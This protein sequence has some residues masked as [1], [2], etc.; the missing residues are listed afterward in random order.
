MAVWLGD[1]TS[2]C[3]ICIRTV[4]FNAHQKQFESDGAKMN[5]WT[6]IAF[7]LQNTISDRCLNRMTV[8]VFAMYF[9]NSETSSIR[10]AFK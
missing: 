8:L 3:N 6:K 10:V 7:V 4:Y 5:Q 1:N 2:K 9:H